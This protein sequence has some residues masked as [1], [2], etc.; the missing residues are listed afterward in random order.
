MK[1]QKTNLI[2][3][4]L[5]PQTRLLKRNLKSTTLPFLSWS[6]PGSSYPGGWRDSSRARPTPLLT[7]EHTDLILGRQQ[8]SAPYTS[9]AS[10]LV[11]FLVSSCL[12]S[13]VPPSSSSSVMVDVSP[14]LSFLYFLVQNGWKLSTLVLL[15][16]GTACLYSLPQVQFSVLN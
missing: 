12:H 3:L 7:V 14:V 9:P 11:V 6:S 13:S 10:L 8:H 15:S 1:T 16:W 4:K 5:G 2:K